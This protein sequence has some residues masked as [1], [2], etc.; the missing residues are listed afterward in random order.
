MAPRIMVPMVLYCTVYKGKEKFIK[1]QYLYYKAESLSVCPG[2]GGAVLLS[3]VPKAPATSLLLE[4]QDVVAAS[5]IDLGVL[6]MDVVQGWLVGAPD[7]LA[8]D[9]MA[10]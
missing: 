1:V 8:S 9:E 10:A 6:P 5:W 2:L 4:L 3:R 7:R